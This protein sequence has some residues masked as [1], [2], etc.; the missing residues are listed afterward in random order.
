MSTVRGVLKKI[1]AKHGTSK[2]GPWTAYSLGMSIDGSDDY[3]WFR[4][5]FSPPPVTEGSFIIFDV[6]E[7]TRSPGAYEV[8]GEI[9]VDKDAT[10]AAAAD[11]TPAPGARGKYA[12][13]DD[14]TQDSIVRQSSMEKAIS[15]VDSML[16]NKVVTLPSTKADKYDF[17]MALVAK[18]TDEFFVQNRHAKTVE[19]IA[20]ASIG[21]EEGAV[22]ESEENDGPVAEPED[23]WTP[24]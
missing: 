8:N 12:K 2:Q 18:L 3:H 13:K 7:S 19:E 1:T 23:A 14:A 5:G 21:P 6:R 22:D 16:T 17:Y 15:A 10:V 20:E 4:Y 9:N 24:V 11:D